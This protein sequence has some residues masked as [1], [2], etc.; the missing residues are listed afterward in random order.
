MNQAASVPSPRSHDPG[1]TVAGGG[2]PR[3]RPLATYLF[4]LGIAVAVPAL[5]FSG[6]LIYRAAES[7]RAGG[8]TG[9]G[10]RGD[11]D[12]RRGRS[13]DRRHGDD[14]E[15]AG[16]VGRARGRRLCVISRRVPRPAS[17]GTQ[18]FVAPRRSAV[19][20][21]PQHARVLR[22]GPRRPR[23]QGLGRR[24]AEDR[25]MCMS[26]ACSSDRAPTS[27]SSTSPC[28]SRSRARPTC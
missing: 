7:E 22:Y 19:P 21:H 28:R 8:R 5:L 10:R 17:Q 2:A 26:R 18:S 16:D 24:A 9:R 6:Y 14:A 25:T 23:Q 1:Q 12:P 13:R 4:L 20:H 15:G 3:G 27:R 11:V